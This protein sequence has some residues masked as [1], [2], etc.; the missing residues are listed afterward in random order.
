VTPE[1]QPN[2]KE[3]ELLDAAVDVPLDFPA[4]PPLS[5]TFFGNTLDLVGP[6]LVWVAVTVAVITFAVGAFGGESVAWVSYLYLVTL[7]TL[8]LYIPYQVRKNRREEITRATRRRKEQEAARTAVLRM[9]LEE[10][11]KNEENK[12]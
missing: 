1:N 4:T 2:S 3:Q 8:V 6:Y 9:V 5:N 10:K 7:V 11:R 12:K